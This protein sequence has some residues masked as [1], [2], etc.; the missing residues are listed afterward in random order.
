[1]SENMSFC[2][3]GEH[4][5]CVHIYSHADWKHMIETATLERM[6]NWNQIFFMKLPADDAYADVNSDTPFIGMKI[7]K[8]ETFFGKFE[9]KFENRFVK[10]YEENFLIYFRVSCGDS[11][12]Y[13]RCSCRA[14][15]KKNVSYTVDVKIDS[16]GGSLRDTVRVCCWYGA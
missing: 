7:E 10:L 1:M 12:T 11:C 9:K 16:R 8:V 15:M 14:E 6:N 5:S 3:V 4:I 13:M 2:V